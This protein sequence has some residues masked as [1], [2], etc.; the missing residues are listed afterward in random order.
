MTD[1]RK[2]ALT[3]FPEIARELG[4]DPIQ[5]LNNHNLPYDYLNNIKIDDLMTL[6][7]AE[8]LLGTLANKTRQHHCGALLGIRHDITF[9]GII[10]YIMTQSI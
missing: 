2:M 8:Q 9:L 5:I 1:L 3:G 10:G 7:E 4:A 6:E